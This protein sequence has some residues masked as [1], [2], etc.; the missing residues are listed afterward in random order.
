V[1]TQFDGISRPLSVAQP[2]GATT[3]TLYLADQALTADPAG[4]AKLLTA[5]RFGNLLTVVEDP[6]SWHGGSL[7]SGRLNYSTSYT[8]L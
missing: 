2:G 6:A 3:T 4:A 8:Y 1:V 5:D 7:G